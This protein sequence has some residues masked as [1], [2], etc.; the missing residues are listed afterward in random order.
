MY[1]HLLWVLLLLLLIV[2]LFSWSNPVSHELPIFFTKEWL[3]CVI[4]SYVILWFNSKDM[5]KICGWRMAVKDLKSMGEKVQFAVCFFCSLR[6]PNYTDGITGEIKN[7]RH[8]LFCYLKIYS[9]P[10]YTSFPLYFSLSYIL[11]IY[12]CIGVKVYNHRC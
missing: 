9:T 11:A 1:L 2:P 12:I 8:Y 3:L 4:L 6:F 10:I 5:C 7:S